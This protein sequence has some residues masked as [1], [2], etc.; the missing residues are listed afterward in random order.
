MYVVTK[1]KDVTKQIFLQ[2][3][4]IHDLDINSYYIVSIF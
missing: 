3:P 1:A 4:V 2:E